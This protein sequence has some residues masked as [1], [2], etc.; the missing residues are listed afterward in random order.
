MYNI[1]LSCIASSGQTYTPVTGKVHQSSQDFYGSLEHPYRYFGNIYGK[2]NGKRYPPYFR[3]DL[4]V[5]R[6]STSIFIFPGIDYIQKLQ[7]INLTNHYNVLLYNWN[8][9]SSPS[10]VIAYSMFPVFISFGL[11]FKL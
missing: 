2:R 6:K 9:E 3:I 8:H 4:S 1:G 11:E 5:S 10:R 7:I